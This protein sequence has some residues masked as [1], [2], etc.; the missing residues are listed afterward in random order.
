MALRINT[1]IASM[2]AHKQLI[3]TDDALSASLARLSSGLRINKAADDASGM[4]I[5]DSLRSQSLGLGQAIR[6]GNDGVSIVQT[7]DAALEESINIVNTIKTKSI[8]AAQDGQTTESRQA[9]QA[10]IT[11]LTEELDTI[12]KTTSFNNQKLLSGNFTDKK[13]QIGAYSGETIDI[14]IQSTEANKIGHISTSSLGFA[15]E[16]T[17]ELA[18][19]SNLQ[20]ATYNLNSVEIA[21]DNTRASSLGAVADSINVLSDL[22][23]ITADASVSSTTT[24]TIAAGTTDDTF[25]INGVKIGAVTIS[26]NDSTGALVSAINQKSD[27]HGITASINQGYLTLTSTDDRAIEVTQDANT[28]A[29]LGGTADMSTLG[30]ITLTQQGTGE[31]QINNRAGGTAVAL[32]DDELA[33]TG[34]TSID[35]ASILA[36]GSVIAAASTIAAGS[37]LAIG[38]TP[39]AIDGAVFTT[40]S[41]TLGTGSEI[42]TGST[43]AANST[44]AGSLTVSGTVT[45]TGTLGLGSTMAAGSTIGCGTVLD[46]TGQ[47]EVD[48]ATGASVGTSTLA[49]RAALVK[50]RV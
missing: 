16:G 39:E 27:Q 34:V 6:N 3:K 46:I 17:A 11:K 33:L 7:A 9:I 21:Y 24:N 18:I 15:S 14:S 32:V 49:P 35:V 48:A 4:T 31:I 40:G 10:D 19:Y 8:Q 45:A 5:A 30:Q 12:A 13:F 42:A 50:E 20:N 43:I 41:S 26:A 25:A 1:N 47:G 29:V 23:G 36:S 44:L 38:T 37:T 28:T 2:N 22:L